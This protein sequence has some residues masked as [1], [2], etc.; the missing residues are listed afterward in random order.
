MPASSAAARWVFQTLAGRLSLRR[1]ARLGLRL[2]L[3][4]HSV[5]KRVCL[6]CLFVSRSE[7]ERERS[8]YRFK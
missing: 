1:D 7:P 8:E 6:E 2:R 5:R 3:Q 4:I